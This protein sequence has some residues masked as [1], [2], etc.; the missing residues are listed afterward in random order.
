MADLG[1]F[2]QEIHEVF[3]LQEFC[4]REGVKECIVSLWVT[5]SLSVN[6]D[7]NLQLN[8][9]KREGDIFFGQ[10]G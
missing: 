2:G 3:T 10:K 1:G 9:T 6:K 5:F 4:Y 8:T 7:K